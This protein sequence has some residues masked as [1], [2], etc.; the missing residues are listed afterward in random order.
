MSSKA[1]D[2]LDSKSNEAVSLR[3]NRPQYYTTRQYVAKMDQFL[4]ALELDHVLFPVKAPKE[5]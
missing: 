4:C 1:I 3:V 2:K 5:S